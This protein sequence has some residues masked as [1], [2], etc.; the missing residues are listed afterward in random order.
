MR[1]RYYFIIYRWLFISTAKKRKDN[2]AVELHI[3]GLDREETTVVKVPFIEKN[4]TW[5]EKLACRNIQYR[6]KQKACAKIW[7]VK[8]PFEFVQSYEKNRH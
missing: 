3:I 1:M 7:R 4:M 6:M 5:E 2:I 8:E